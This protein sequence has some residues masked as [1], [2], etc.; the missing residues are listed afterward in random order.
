LH[1]AI[2]GVMMGTFRHPIELGAG[3]AGPFETLEPLVGTGATYTTVPATVLDKLGVTP[4]RRETFVLADGRRVTRPLGRAWV[5]IDGR[6]ESTVVVFGDEGTVLLGA[7][8][9]EGLSLAADPVNR[10]LVP[11]PELYLL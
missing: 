3:P 2:V 9:L 8:T 4:H 7:Y 1:D 6:D 11:L 5:R 10:R